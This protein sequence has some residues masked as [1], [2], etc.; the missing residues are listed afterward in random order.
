M[1]IEF[2]GVLTALVTPFTT[3]DAID[4]DS[5]RRLIDFQLEA[6]VDGFVAAG[7]TGEGL[8]L[9]D[10]EYSELISS[11]RR[12]I[13]RDLPCVAGVSA[14]ATWRGVEL[15]LLA[16][17][18]GADGLLVANPPYNKPSQA[19]ITLHLESIG[20]STGLPLIAYNI[21][22]RSGA[23]LLPETAVEL[24]RRGTVVAIKESSGVIENTIEILRCSAP[25]SIVLSGEDSLVGPIL[26]CGGSGVIS[27]A[28]NIDPALFVAIV[29]AWRAGDTVGTARAQ[30]A[31]LP[32]VRAAF[33]ESNPVPAKAAL[34]MMGILRCGAP[35]APLLSATE[36]TR[37]LFGS[38][39]PNRSLA[40][41][42]V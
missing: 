6:G 11:V 34:E 15:G 30:A 19:G 32:L 33:S 36:K 8:A 42:A 18:A 2:T 40:S 27:A 41:V 35:R 3:S 23:P 17:E 39:L 24:L 9:R 1:A 21:P 31:A 20:R 16:K 4:F 22:G 7:S 37:A 10:A 28:A 14:S 12:H 26:A 38:A 29:R 25:G 13:G 5:L